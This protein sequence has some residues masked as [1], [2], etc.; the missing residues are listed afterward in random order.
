LIRHELRRARGERS[1][2]AV[3]KELGIRQQYLSKI[4]LG[5][6]CPNAKI[7]WRIAQ[8]YSKPVDDLFPDIFM[9]TQSF[10]ENDKLFNDSK[11]IADE[12]VII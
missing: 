10:N 2:I 5:M 9:H 11:Y 8:Y 7:V 4:E 3:A 6:H 1:Q 12:T